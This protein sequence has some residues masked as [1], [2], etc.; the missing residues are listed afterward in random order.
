MKIFILILF[1][2]S[3]QNILEFC[4]LIALPMYVTHDSEST[5]LGEIANFTTKV[6]FLANDKHLIALFHECTTFDLPFLWQDFSF[7]ETNLRVSAREMIRVSF[8]HELWPEIKTDVFLE[9]RIEFQTNHLQKFKGE[10]D[11]ANDYLTIV[12]KRRKE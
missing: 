12:G 6:S 10:I 11:S 9:Y 2:K 1:T 5:I 3:V 4:S 8:L 7:R